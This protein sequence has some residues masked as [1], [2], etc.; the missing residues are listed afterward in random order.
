MPEVDAEILKEQIAK[1]GKVA[2]GTANSWP[3][4]VTDESGVSGIYAGV[5]KAVTE[6][7][8]VG[9]FCHYGLR[10]VDP[11]SPFLSRRIDVVASA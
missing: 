9:R 8:G 10:R 3:W 11:Q 2:T 5:L 1:E 4:G 6:S 7:L